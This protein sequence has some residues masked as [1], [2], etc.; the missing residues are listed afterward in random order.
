MNEIDKMYENAG[1][2]PELLLD[3][4]TKEEVARRYPPFTLEK[5]LELVKWL[6]NSICLLCL[7]Q[8][9]HSDDFES[10]LA[11]LVNCLWQD[12]EEEDKQQ[13]KEILR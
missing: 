10:D 9:Q 1:V 8:L 3:A 6:F 2:E 5:Q 4:K 13:I 12:L 7:G 11:E